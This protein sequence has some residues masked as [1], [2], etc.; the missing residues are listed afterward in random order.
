MLGL[1][2]LPSS[3]AGRGGAGN[4]EA[5]ILTCLAVTGQARALESPGGAGR[6][7]AVRGGA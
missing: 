2:M 4:A 7:G 1:R 5:R 6:R 3:V